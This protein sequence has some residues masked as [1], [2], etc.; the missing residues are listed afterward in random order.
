M[1]ESLRSLRQDTRAIKPAT[2]PGTSVATRYD[3]F[4]VIL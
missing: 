4:Q 3:G 2:Y 1:P